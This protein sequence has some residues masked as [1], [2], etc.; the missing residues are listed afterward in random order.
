LRG[1]QGKRQQISLKG[2]DKEKEEGRLNRKRRRGQD[3]TGEDKR[4][5][6]QDKT[7]EDKRREEEDKREDRDSTTKGR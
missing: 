4:R 3:R 6:R 7:R 2:I 5:R 1:R